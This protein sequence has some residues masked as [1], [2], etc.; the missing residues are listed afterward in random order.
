MVRVRKRTR[1]LAR[2]NRFWPG[3]LLVATLIGTSAAAPLD[4][5]KCYKLK[6]STVTFTPQ[7][8]TLVDQF[9]TEQP[10]VQTPFR[11]CNPVDKDGGG[12]L[13]P[14]AHLN[15]YTIFNRGG[16]A[17]RNRKVTVSNQFGEQELTLVRPYSLCVPAE[18]DGVTSALAIDHFKCYQVE[19]TSGTP[20]FKFRTV[21]LQDQFE[22]K[23]TS[24]R[25]PLLFCDAVDK[26]G[27]GI[28]DPAAQLTCYRILDTEGQP[29][30]QPRP[31]TIDDQFTGETATAIRGVCRKISLL[32]VPPTTT[33][34]TTITTTSTST[35]STSST[36]TS[37]TSTSTTSTSSSSTSTSTST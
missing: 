11:F 21:V 24:V 1:K 6:Q 3:L 20:P 26:N 34:T 31:V 29:E 9:G 8:V 27:E 28:L 18:K 33:S 23:I 5:F 2:R 7:Q 4:H 25:A 13:D 17:F 16:P 22:S 10:T 14:T 19:R 12:I 15:C 37:T 36:S 35:S 32:C 30:F